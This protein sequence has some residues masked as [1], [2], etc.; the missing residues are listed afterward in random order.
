[1]V[2]PLDSTGVCPFLKR[3]KREYLL[4]NLRCD[5]GVGGCKGT[6]PRPVY[7]LLVVLVLVLSDGGEASVPADRGLEVDADVFR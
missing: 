6:V 1:M 7:V 3:F 4:P 5:G 2:P